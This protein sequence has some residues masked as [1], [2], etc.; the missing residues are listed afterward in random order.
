MLKNVKK[1]SRMLSKNVIELSCEKICLK[2]NVKNLIFKQ[3][4]KKICNKDSAVIRL[5]TN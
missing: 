5:E 3:S 2:S 1:N 4:N